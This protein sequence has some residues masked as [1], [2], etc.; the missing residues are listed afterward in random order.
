MR[1]A[2]LIGDMEAYK[3]DGQELKLEAVFCTHPLS[4]FSRTCW[5]SSA[6]AVVIMIQPSLSD[7]VSARSLQHPMNTIPRRQR[8]TALPAR[9]GTHTRLLLDTHR[10]SS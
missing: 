3:H 4:A 2:G 10:L 1:L 5:Y 6:N 8:N 9:G 7:T